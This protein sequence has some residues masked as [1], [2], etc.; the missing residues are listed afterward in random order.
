MGFLLPQKSE[1]PNIDSL[2]F[3]LFFSSHS[4]LSPALFSSEQRCQV[5]HSYDK[6]DCHIGLTG[7]F[8]EELQKL[9]IL[10]SYPLNSNELL[11]YKTCKMW[12]PLKLIYIILW[13]YSLVFLVPSPSP[14]KNV[15][16]PPFSV[17]LHSFLG[18]KECLSRWRTWGFSVQKQ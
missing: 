4:S 3:L 6:T 17:L 18:A 10:L 14:S 2:V 5:S 12:F 8:E 15:N 1:A 13:A 7:P 11:P 16:P 9:P